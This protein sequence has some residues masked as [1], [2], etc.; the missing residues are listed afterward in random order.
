MEIV[1]G[2]EWL[3]HKF[4]LENVD[5]PASL[6]LN[7][8]MDVTTL[9]W[10]DESLKAIKVDKDKLPPV[11]DSDAAGGHVWPRRLPRLDLRRAC[12]TASG[13]GDQQ[14]AA[15]GAGV[16]R[17][18]LTE[19]NHRDGL[20]DGRDVDSSKPVIRITWFCS[21][22]HAIPH[23]GRIWKAWLSATGVCPCAVARH[24]CADGSCR[25]KADGFGPV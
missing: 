24:L 14:C 16:I 9:D 18:G 8:M 10:S 13:G 3:L 25:C 1:N 23:K 7:G 21:S 11:K 20:G 17:E 5:H 12:Q 22:G 6:A 4:G 19:I 2:Q 15:I